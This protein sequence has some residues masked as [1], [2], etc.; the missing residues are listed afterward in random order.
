MNKIKVFGVYSLPPKLLICLRLR[1]TKD[2]SV[3]YKS[4]P[5]FAG[6]D[7]WPLL[8]SNKKI[9]YL[10]GHNVIMLENICQGVAAFVS[11]TPIKI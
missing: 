1:V 2:H 6:M 10:F 4:T 3:T 9:I 11:A 7:A 8:R 5:G